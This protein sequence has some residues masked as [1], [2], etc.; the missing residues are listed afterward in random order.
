[1]YGLAF[2][3]I[4]GGGMEVIGRSVKHLK[5][6]TLITGGEYS[7]AV[8]HVPL[9]EKLS[10]VFEIKTW[11]KLLSKSRSQILTADDVRDILSED[12]IEKNYLTD[13]V[14]AIK[15]GVPADAHV[16]DLGKQL[17]AKD[18]EMIAGFVNKQDGEYLDKWLKFE[19]G[20]D[21]MQKLAQFVRVQQL[22]G[23]QRLYFGMGDAEW[24]VVV[25]G[26]TDR[27]E[28]VAKH[29]FE[30]K[31]DSR[32]INN[33]ITKPEETIPSDIKEAI[34][35]ITNFLE[36][37]STPEQITVYRGEGYYGIFDNNVTLTGDK[38]SNELE[39]I[40]REMDLGTLDKKDLDF[41]INTELIQ[42]KVTQPRFLSTSMDKSSTESY[43][44][45]VQWNITVPKGTKGIQIEP[46]NVERKA[47]DEFLIQRG[48]TLLIVDAFYDLSRHLWFIDAV[49]K[50]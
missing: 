19:D 34:D 50:Q 31:K 22:T 46:Y 48:S 39:R 26:V 27:P 16:L 40:A 37:Q 38:L 3:P 4:I 10:A 43:A 12:F 30:Y 44:K 15:R 17:T 25:D 18:Y 6:P 49:L 29:F 33:C 42:V 7:P 36:K 32:I 47:E 2:S 11:Q 20:V 13:F 8:V 9:E 5:E 24:S 41:F 23:K 1:V 35:G 14:D 45:V 28:E 21:N